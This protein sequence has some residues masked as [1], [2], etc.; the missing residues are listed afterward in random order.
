[1]PDMMVVVAFQRCS[2]MLCCRCEYGG[3]CFLE[4]T[5]LTLEESSETSEATKELLSP[6]YQDF[7]P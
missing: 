4:N 1:M 6:S 7:P 3:K 2:N 5:N